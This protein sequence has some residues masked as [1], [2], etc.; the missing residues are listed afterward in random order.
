M[1]LRAIKLKFV[2]DVWHIVFSPY[3]TISCIN[4]SPVMNIK[5]SVVIPTHRPDAVRLD[6]TLKALKRQTLPLD[7]WELLIIDNATPDTNYVSGFSPDWHP[8]TKVIRE[9]KIGLTRARLAGIDASQGQYLIFVD[10]DNELEPAYLEHAIKLFKDYPHVGVAGGKSIPE[11]AV[12]PEDWVDNFWLCLALRDYGNDIQIYSHRDDSKRHPYFAPIGAG[13]ALRR[14]AAIYYR[15][16]IQS[17]P[18][19]LS[20]DRT[21]K[22]LQSGGDCDINLTLLAGGWAV[23]YFPQ[24]QLTHLIAADR[25]SKYYLAKLNYAS[26]RSWIHVLAVHD[27]YPWRSISK[28]GV[29]PRKLKA[30]FTYQ[31]WKSDEAFIRWKGA[32]GSFEGLSQ[33]TDQS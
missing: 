18:N 7:E 27:I 3:L 22:S 20:F 25:L 4:I 29:L 12:E 30:F 23:G 19:R 10:D 2:A 9:E 16:C 6:R 26:S 5:I 14:E 8:H 28:W 1:K 21:G 13:M 31:P 11:F 32:C 15:D 24:L 17:D 33:I